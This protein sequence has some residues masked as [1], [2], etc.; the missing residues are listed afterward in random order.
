MEYVIMFE[1]LILVLD[2]IFFELLNGLS[3]LR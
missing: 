1:N 2:K 3:G